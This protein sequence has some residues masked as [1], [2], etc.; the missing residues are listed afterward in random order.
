[1]ST[2]YDIAPKKTGADPS[3]WT[4]VDTGRPPAGYMACPNNPTP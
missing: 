4:A 1:M 2:I 3:M